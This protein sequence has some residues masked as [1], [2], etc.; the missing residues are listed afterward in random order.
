M[1]ILL[2][3]DDIDSRVTLSKFLHRLGH[4]VE[5]ADDGLEALSLFNN[6]YFHMI[7][8]DLKMPKMSGIDLL[9]NIATGYPDR[10]VA[11]VLFTGHGDLNSAIEAI[12]AGAYDYL[13]KPVDIK[14]LAVLVDRIAKY[15]NSKKENIVLT[16]RFKSKVKAAAGATR[17]D[18][19]RIKKSHAEQAGIGG[20]GIFSEVMTGIFEQ[21]KKFNSDRSIPVLIQGETGIG[22]EAVARYI[23]YGKDIVTLPF[24]DINCA[25]IPPNI[26]ESELFGYEAGAF[27]GGLQKGQRGKLDLADG[28]TLFLDEITELPLELQA[29][30]LRVIQEKEY[31]R[32]GGLKKMKADLR[33][34]CATNADIEKRLEQGRFRQDLYYR[35]N[36]GRIIIPPLRERQNE[37]LPLAKMF[38]K[39]FAQK[40]NKKFVGISNKAASALQSYHWP[41]NV[42]ELKNTIE[43]IVFMYDDNELKIGHLNAIPQFQ[44]ARDASDSGVTPVTFDNCPLPPDRL[45]L[46]DLNKMLI[47]R[48][49]DMHNGNKTKTAEYLGMSRRMLQYRLDRLGK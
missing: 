10:E 19:V 1:N 11:M 48:A 32:V 31:Y 25:A 38:I 24:V 49:L 14:E 2:V 13:L 26:F 16:E 34:I 3:E 7:L 9:K 33:I 47:R 28:G 20:I 27:T 30:L 42:R 22:K 41:G 12:R 15:Q 8:T 40:R 36:I 17:N 37:I 6:G 43:Y 4:Y 29:K 45:D 35:I 46:A 39:R 23:H 5:E 21:A 44:N 18:L